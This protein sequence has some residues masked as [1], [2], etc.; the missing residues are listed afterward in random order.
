MEKLLRRCCLLLALGCA[1]GAARGAADPPPVYPEAPGGGPRFDW[2]NADDGLG[3]KVLRRSDVEARL[4][5]PGEVKWWPYDRREDTGGHGDMRYP[6]LGFKFQIN[7][8]D[9]DDAD[10]RIGWITLGLPWDGHTPQ[11]L[12]LGMEER[13]AMAIIEGWYKVRGS[14][15]LSWGQG[16]QSRGTAVLAGNRGWRKTQAITFTFREKR[17]HR[18][19]AQLKPTPLVRLDDVLGLLRTVVT[20]GLLALVG[21]GLRAVRQRLGPTWERLRTL[22]GFA[23]LGAGGFAI[24]AGVATFGSGD[25]YARMAGLM[26]GLGGAGMLFF[27]LVLLARSRNAVISGFSKGILFAALAIIVVATLIR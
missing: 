17:L 16:G 10:P 5:Q 13:E 21:T 3:R 2:I 12:Y 23:V 26:I 18:I 25:G 20:I 27:A 14:I 8:E 9:A 19:E 24:Y 6:A 15:P 4:G 11:G 22:L 7:P 1:V